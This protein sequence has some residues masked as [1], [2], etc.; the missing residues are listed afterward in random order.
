MHDKISY[1]MPQTTLKYHS[2]SS[3]KTGTINGGYSF[4]GRTVH[5]SGSIQHVQQCSS[6][7]FSKGITLRLIIKKFW[8][9][10]SPRCPFIQQVSYFQDTTITLCNPI[11]S[12]VGT[13]VISLTRSCDYHQFI[14]ATCLISTLSWSCRCWQVWWLNKTSKTLSKYSMSWWQITECNMCHVRWEQR[15]LRFHMLWYLLLQFHLFSYTQAVTALQW[16][17]P[18]I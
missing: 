14:L 16:Y 7:E 11:P 4:F 3:R 12:V 13:F 15:S 17:Y 2:S 9:Q 5:D 8:Y 10:E 1:N 6:R 18:V